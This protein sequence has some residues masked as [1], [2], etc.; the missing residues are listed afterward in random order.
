MHSLTTNPSE[1]ATELARDALRTLQ[2]HPLRSRGAAVTLRAEAGARS[3]TM[4]VPREAFELLVEILGQMANGQA[5]TLVPTHAEVTTQQAAEMINVSRPFLIGLLDE[6]KI[7][8]RKVGSHRRVR[9]ADVLAY[10]RRDDVA[11]RAALDA[12]TAEGQALGMGY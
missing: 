7:P 3:A 8:F 10:K 4:A 5:V 9:V 1:K 2:E 12:L 6:G 11:R